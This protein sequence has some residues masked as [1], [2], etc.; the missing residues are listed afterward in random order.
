[1]SQG[2]VFLAKRVEDEKVRPARD[3]LEKQESLLCASADAA[4][5]G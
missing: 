5:Q 4:L 3:A 1:M 2:C